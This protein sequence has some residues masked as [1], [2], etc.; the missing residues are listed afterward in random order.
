L[1]AFPRTNSHKFSILVNATSPNPSQNSY[2]SYWK[3]F[4]RL[5][6]NPNYPSSAL[7]LPA[8]PPRH[9]SYLHISSLA[10]AGVEQHPHLELV[11]LDPEN[12]VLGGPPERPEPVPTGHRLP[13][14]ISG[15][16]RTGDVL[17]DLDGLVA[18]VLLRVGCNKRAVSEVRR[19]NPPAAAAAVLM[20]RAR[21]S[22]FAV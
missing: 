11:E 18:M 9:E 5:S 1:K 7:N 12:P 15:H 6:S 4:H 19:H 10:V 20:S 2:P 8:K 21:G 3:T 22:N 14:I 17:V 13:E 16:F